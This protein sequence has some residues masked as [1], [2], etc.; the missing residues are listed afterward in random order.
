VIFC[1]SANI[2]PAP[3]GIGKYTLRVYSPTMRQ[4]SYGTNVTGEMI[5]ATDIRTSADTLFDVFWFKAALND[6]VDIRMNSTA[7]AS[8]FVLQPN[9]GAPSFSP[10]GQCA[11]CGDAGLGGVGR[12][13]SL[14]WRIGDTGYEDIQ[15]IL[16]TPYE[17]N[18]TGA[19][20][21]SL[22]RAASLT[23]ETDTEAAAAPVR[24]ASSRQP[25]ARAG[26]RMIEE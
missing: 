10:G 25:L 11:S 21:L 24:Q 22:N 17:P 8:F 20:T 16:V 3:L 13:A 23:T 6:N 5:S 4:I 18:K 2:Q 1:S 19:Y 26:S 9:G 14:R 12:E 7:F 15:L